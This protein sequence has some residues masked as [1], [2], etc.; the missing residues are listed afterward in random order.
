MEHSNVYH[1]V[2]TLRKAKTI[3]FTQHCILYAYILIFFDCAHFSSLSYGISSR[4]NLM[5]GDILCDHRQL[6]FLVFAELLWSPINYMASRPF[7]FLWEKAI[8]ILQIKIL[9]IFNIADG[10][11]SNWTLNNKYFRKYWLIVERFKLLFYDISRWPYTRFVLLLCKCKQ[12][13]C[14][15]KMTYHPWEMHFM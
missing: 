7:F 12:H 1:I 6:I 5:M 15:Y 13:I 10:N 4:G 3:C 11:V 2:N 8:F 14:W 9:C